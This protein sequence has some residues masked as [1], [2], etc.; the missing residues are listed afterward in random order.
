MEMSIDEKKEFSLKLFI[1]Y[2][3]WIHF[4]GCLLYFFS[5]V[6]SLLRF[7]MKHCLLFEMQWNKRYSADLSLL[8]YRPI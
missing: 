3:L 5:D 7:A 8:F 4:F 1:N 2:T 6:V